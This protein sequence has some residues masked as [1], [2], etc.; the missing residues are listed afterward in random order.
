MSFGLRIRVYVPDGRSYEFAAPN[1]AREG[2]LLRVDPPGHPNLEHWMA[3]VPGPG[4]DPGPMAVQFVPQ[5]AADPNV[6][7]M[8]EQPAFTAG[9]R[10][11]AVRRLLMDHERA[12]DVAADIGA[13]AATVRR[14][15]SSYD[16]S[17][18]RARATV[19]RRGMV[20]SFVP[21]SRAKRS[22]R[23]TGRRFLMAENMTPD[24]NWALLVDPVWQ[25]E[26]PDDMPPAEVMV[27]GWLL[28]D[29]GVPGRF[30]PNPDYEPAAQ[31]GATDPTDAVI[32][33]VTQGME[34][35]ES[36]I[37]TLRDALVELA[38]TEDGQLLVGPAPDGVSCVAV[39]TAGVQRRRTPFEHWRQVTVERI[40]EA[41]PQD[42]DILLNPA[43]ARP[44]RVVADT[45]RTSIAED[46]ENDRARQPLETSDQ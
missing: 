34:S 1:P 41:L 3:T 37:P 40:V 31:D 27:G 7:G 5:G 19:S 30:T 17:A 8:R 45:L 6:S 46:P 28:D 29:N 12:E 36:L 20:V 44:F 15:L 21:E 10:Y 25:A 39:A 2:S 42:V 13:Q 18:E 9:Q 22:L 32:Q 14:W 35:A 43:G 26:S 11:N 38:V 16:V 4:D 33:L 23:R 24:S